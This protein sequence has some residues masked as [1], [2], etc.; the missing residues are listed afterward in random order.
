MA[1]RHG[2][3]VLELG[4]KHDGDV[5]DALDWSLDHLDRF[6]CSD[7]VYDQDGL[8]LGLAREVERSLAPR[9]IRYEGFRGGSTPENPSAMY[10]GHRTNRDAFA[11]RRCQAYFSLR[12]RFWKTYQAVQGEFHDPDELIFLPKDHPLI[13]Q[14]RSE[15][16]RIPVVPHPA[17]KIALMSKVNMKKPPYNL[18]S[19]NLADALVYSFTV[20]DYISGSWGKPLEYKEA[21]I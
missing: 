3:K 7:F 17:G 5:G 8:G 16:C 4:L 12:E 13:G 19:P 9:N 15:I 10:D 18:P 6:H 2:A 14:L 20:S 21:Y 11:N 1:I